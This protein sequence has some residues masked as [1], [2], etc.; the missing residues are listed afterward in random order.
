MMTRLLTGLNDQE[1][2]KAW[3]SVQAVL[4]F[5]G[6]LAPQ[7]LPSFRVWKAA[8]IAEGK[9]RRFIDQCY[10]EKISLRAGVQEVIREVLRSDF[11]QP[12]QAIFAPE[13]E[14]PS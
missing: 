8:V 5:A 7:V 2:R 14:M 4:P 1:W 3:A 10:G 11:P 6:N 13:M 12:P 9:N